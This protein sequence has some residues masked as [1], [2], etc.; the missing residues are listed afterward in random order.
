[1]SQDGSGY[2][3]NLRKQRSVVVSGVL[4]NK[5]QVFQ[6]F[7]FEYDADAPPAAVI[8]QAFA[9]IRQIGGITISSADNQ[10]MDFYPLVKFDKVNF[11]IKQVELASIS[12]Q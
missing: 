4:P 12:I 6:E 1:M 11:A 7:K 5:E 9:L 10:E 8:G 2:Q 3:L